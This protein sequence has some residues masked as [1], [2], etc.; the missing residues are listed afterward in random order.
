MSSALSA[1]KARACLTPSGLCVIPSSGLP[2]SL[3]LA[4]PELTDAP[5]FAAGNRMILRTAPT[6]WPLGKAVSVTWQGETVTGLVTERCIDADDG[7]GPWEAQL[8]AE[9]ENSP[10]EAPG[11]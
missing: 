9:T 7:D 2:V 10:G 1:A 8:L 6:G 4:T 5:A 3:H 11:E